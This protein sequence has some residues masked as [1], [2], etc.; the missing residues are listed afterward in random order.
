M[1]ESH[2]HV[3]HSHFALEREYI[4]AQNQSSPFYQQER[5]AMLLI[6]LLPKSSENS[7][8][9]HVLPKETK[10]KVQPK[11]YHMRSKMYAV[12]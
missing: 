11:G 9:L 10:K 3:T 5:E 8:R 6:G 1:M 12:P 2:K 4:P 7:A